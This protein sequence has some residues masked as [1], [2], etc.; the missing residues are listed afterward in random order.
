MLNLIFSYIGIGIAIVLI[1]ATLWDILITVLSH[2]GVGKITKFWTEGIWRLVLW[3]K[4]QKGME[5]PI[6]YS[7]PF[8]LVGI[9]A[10]WYLILNVSYL[11]L[12]YCGDFTIKSADDPVIGFMDVLY[13]VGTTFSGL[14]IG[15]YVPTE[16]PWTMVTTGGAFLVSLITSFAVSYLIP[17]VSSVA[18]RRRLMGSMSCIGDRPKEI[19]K[20]AW[21]QGSSGQLDSQV[22]TMADS[23]IEASFRSHIYPIVNFFYF[24]GRNSSMNLI[25]LD[26]LDVMIFQ[27]CHP[28][29]EANIHESKRSYILRAIE[30]Y[31]DNQR[32]NC[33][34]EDCGRKAEHDD[35]LE[36]LETGDA[37]ERSQDRIR[38]LDKFLEQRQLLLAYAHYEGH[39]PLN[40]N[41]NLSKPQ[42]QS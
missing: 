25:I 6:R 31:I 15:D 34:E 5:R 28:Q 18:E 2:R 35:L 3:T 1:C 26:L 36:F 14:G 40:S 7:G 9:I 30:L 19:L 33:G 39:C 37:S 13:F 12:I 21:G 42:P 38:K 41:Q 17:V 11:L 22:L 32:N 16:F 20:E 4:Y 27:Y 24:K 8:F 23:I 10:V 29:R